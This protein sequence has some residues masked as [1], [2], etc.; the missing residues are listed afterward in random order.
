MGYKSLLKEV[1]FLVGHIR[2]KVSGEY[3]EQFLNACIL[4]NI[5][6]R[7]LKR[8]GSDLVMNIPL[9]C[10]ETAEQLA[11]RMMLEFTIVKKS[12]SIHFGDFV[13]SRVWLCSILSLFTV[14]LVISQC[15]V[16]RIEIVGN[17]LVTD[18]EIL[19]VL[20]QEGIGIGS[21]GSR[22]DSQWLKPRVLLKIPELSWFYINIKGC[23]AFVNVREHTPA[24][25]VINEQ[26]FLDLTADKSGMVKNIDVHS[27]SAA[28]K[29][30]DMIRKGEVVI[31]SKVESEYTAARYVR[32]SGVV[33]GTTWYTIKLQIPLTT[34]KKEFTGKEK[35]VKSIIF[36]GK[37]INLSIL[38]GI[39]YVFYDKITLYENFSLPGGYVLPFT[40]EKETLKEVR[41]VQTEVDIDDALID[42][43]ECIKNLVQSELGEGESIDE[44]K[45]DSHV[46]GDVLIVRAYVRCSEILAQ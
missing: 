15:M 18:E 16:L 25:E 46:Q 32:A 36:S 24:P 37:R 22:I 4:E 40:L 14:F 11:L 33:K 29:S 7:K 42:A 30:G 12:P 20:R 35:T 28:V 1:R 8:Q 41:L 43:E 21:I 26:E 44:I 34:Q 13:K 39:P 3:P 5:E 27:G 10:L 38:Y 17:K 45:V 9:G 6:F 19:W 2:I 23:T 31:S